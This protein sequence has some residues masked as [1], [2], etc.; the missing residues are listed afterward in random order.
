MAAFAGFGDA[1]RLLTF[2]EHFPDLS[3]ALEMI[4]L[5]TV[6]VQQPSAASA[7]AVASESSD[8]DERVYAEPVDGWVPAVADAWTAVDPT[9]P[10]S[11]D[12][13]PRPGDVEVD[14]EGLRPGS[15]TPTTRTTLAEQAGQ[16]QRTVIAHVLRP[17]PTPERPSTTFSYRSVAR[18]QH[19][20]R[21]FGRPLW[22]NRM[23]WRLAVECLAVTGKRPARSLDVAACVEAIARHEIID[24]LPIREKGARRGVVDTILRDTTLANGPLAADVEAF[25]ASVEANSRTAF[26][27][28][29]FCR[30]TDA[31]GCGAGPI[32]TWKPL[33]ESTLGRRVIVVSSVPA[34]AG[35]RGLAWRRLAES[36]TAA[37]HD[38]VF[39][40]V[41]DRCEWADD[42]WPGSWFSLVC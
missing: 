30:T 19:G 13:A 29:G 24:R 38:F 39:V 27:S 14:L 41:G 23:A 11:S 2:R 35:R 33:E 36:L 26:E 34:R 12:Q 28:V 9:N 4:G 42:D 18:G 22:P 32:W 15:R 17:A 6:A 31:M 3:L 25:I 8:E 1:V 21:A 20:R 10:H 7:T 5:A 37:G 16:R 40:N